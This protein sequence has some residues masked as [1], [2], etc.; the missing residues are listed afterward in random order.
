LFPSADAA[1][2]LSCALMST[3]SPGEMSCGSG[4]A[5]WLDGLLTSVPSGRAQWYDSSHPAAV[6]VLRVGLEMVS[7]VV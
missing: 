5:T 2:V 1:G 4:V 6:Q 3:V 7:G